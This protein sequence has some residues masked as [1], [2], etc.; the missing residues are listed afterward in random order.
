[1]G[2]SFN[3]NV[4]YFSLVKIDSPFYYITILLLDFGFNPIED[5]KNGPEI[6]KTG[7]F[8]PV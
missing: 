3:F 2:H 6:K 1:M 8:I 5:N 4:S 7:N